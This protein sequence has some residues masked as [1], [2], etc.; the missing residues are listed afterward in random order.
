MIKSKKPVK[1]QTSITP[2][3]E[4]SNPFAKRTR[5]NM[6]FK[7]ETP[8]LSDAEIK[9]KIQKYPPQPNFQKLV[10]KLFRGATTTQEEEEFSINSNKRV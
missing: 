3:E 6:M 10:Q 1:I 7:G 5:I 9:S 2:G 4:D 8:K